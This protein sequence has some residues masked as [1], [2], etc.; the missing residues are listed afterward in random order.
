LRQGRGKRKK[1]EKEGKWGRIFTVYVRGRRV[2]GGLRYFMKKEK[3]A[4]E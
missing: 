2:D 1:G 4:N 3:K